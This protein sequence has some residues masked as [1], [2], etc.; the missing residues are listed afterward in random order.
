MQYI[1]IY[2]HT[3]T[4]THA[5]AHDMHM[6]MSHVHVH[7]HVHVHVTFI[8]LY[9]HGWDGQGTSVHTERHSDSILFA[10]A[11]LSPATHPEVRGQ[12]GG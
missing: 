10:D 6:H 5:H 3:Y 8:R 9:T 2:I 11:S 4:Y 1:R 7:A 12:K